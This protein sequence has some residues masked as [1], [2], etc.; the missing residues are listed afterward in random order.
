MSPSTM[1]QALRFLG[2]AS[3]IAGQ[4]K[5]VVYLRSKAIARFVCGSVESSKGTVASPG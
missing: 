3:V 2:G 5:Y 4:E 1:T